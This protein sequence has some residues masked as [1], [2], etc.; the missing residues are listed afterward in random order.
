MKVVICW[1]SVSGYMTS[2]WRALAASP[3]V[4]LRL[5]MFPTHSAANAPFDLN[6]TRGLACEAL[7]ERYLDAADHVAGLVA[8][9]RPDVVVVPG[10]AVPAFTTLPFDPRLA[11]VRFIMAMDTPRRDDW[12]QKLA[13]F[14]LGRLLGRMDRVIVAGERSWQYAK[15]LGVD[16]SKL[17]RGMYGVDFAQLQPLHQRRLSRPGGWPR[18]FVFAGRYIDLKGIDLLLEAH[19]IYRESHADAWPLTCCGQGPLGQMVR[20]AGDMVEDMGFVQPRLMPEVWARGGAFVLSSRFDPWPLALVEACAA[21]LPVLCTEACGSAVELVRQRYNGLSVATGSA[22]ALA[23]GMATFHEH[24]DEL[25]EMGRRSLGFAAAF[26]ADAWAERWISMFEELV[27]RPA[28]L[29][30]LGMLD[31]EQL[32]PQSDRPS[33]QVAQGQAAGAG[34]FFAL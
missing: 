21:G 2:C 24:Y 6:L 16:E 14:K 8:A 22:A 27:P 34:G 20:A 31:P 15:Q 9:H 33:R 4:D 7:D 3:G 26:S 12:R 23:R 18:R 10:W 13:R 5:V 32:Q 28:S 19:A 1:T 29:H 25:P 30:L 17:R 11:G